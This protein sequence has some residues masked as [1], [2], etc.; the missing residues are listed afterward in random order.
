MTSSTTSA[1]PPIASRSRRWP[2]PGRPTRPRRPGVTTSDARP[3]LTITGSHGDDPLAA[4]V[5]RLGL[6]AFVELRGWLSRDEL[7]GLYAE[8]TALVFPT[9]F[10]GFGLPPLEAM[11]RGCPVIVSDIPVMHE[12]A[13]DAALYVDPLDAESIAGGIRS[14]LQAPRERE[15]MSRAGLARA[16]EFSWEATADATRA[17]VLAAG[18]RRNG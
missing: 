10:E 4:V 9:R 1:F 11:S 3:R 12:V 14:L 2:A 15:R 13:G 6:G 5:D 18:M 17:A 8:A 7:E 16:A